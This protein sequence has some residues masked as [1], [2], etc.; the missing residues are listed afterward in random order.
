MTIFYN[1][2]QPQNIKDTYTQYEQ[3]DFLVKTVPGR[4]IVAG[5]FRITGV[6]NVTKAL[7]ATPTTYAPI[8]AADNVFC[9]PYAGAHVFIQNA[10]VSINDRTIESI[11]YYPRPVVMDTIARNTL[12]Q[13]TACSD[14]A[15]EMKGNNGNVILSKQNAPFRISPNLSLNKSSAN[16]PAS[17]YPMMKVMLTLSS[18]L[19]ALY[20]SI[21]QP[22]ADPTNIIALNYTISQLQLHWIE[23]PEAKQ[24][25][26]EIVFNTN[27]LVTQ[28]VVSLNTTLNVVAP[29]PYDAVAC[30]FISQKNRNNLW[31]DGNM[32]EYLMDIDRVS[33]ELN[34]QNYGPLTYIIGAGASPPYQDL[35]LNALKALK[36]DPEKNSIVN[37]ILQEN[38]CFVIGMSY[39]ANQGDKLGITMQID[40]ATEFQYSA[41]PYD[42]LLYVNGYATV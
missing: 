4:E 39:A 40:S 30:S 9:N 1:S 3:V 5:S 16:L 38:G 42:C 17:K 14:S 11:A 22:A 25:P 35:A 23:N 32:C 10:T 15:V 29:N 19:D 31:C 21:P 12:E 33:F 18:A 8:A 13:L 7:A 28:T 36:G 34:N 26:K 41:H 2:A 6:L 37:R 27:Y 20:V 24:Q